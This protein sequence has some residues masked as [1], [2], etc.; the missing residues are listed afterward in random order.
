MVTLA[1]LGLQVR[2]M[3]SHLYRRFG[4]AGGMDGLVGLLVAGHVMGH[5]FTRIESALLISRVS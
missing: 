4:R 1:G 5:S 3:P 2:V